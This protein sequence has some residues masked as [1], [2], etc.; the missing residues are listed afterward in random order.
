MYN[1]LGVTNPMVPVVA[2]PKRCSVSIE[3]PAAI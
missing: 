2:D 3:A 1:E